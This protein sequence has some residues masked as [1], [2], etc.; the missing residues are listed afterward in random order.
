MESTKLK[1][2]IEADSIDEIA[3]KMVY[4]LKLQNEPAKTDSKA[5]RID[6][7]AMVMVDGSRVQIRLSNKPADPRA[8]RGITIDGAT[9]G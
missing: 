8:R 6:N 4:L 5:P 2:V 7:M 9:L 1:Y 3:S